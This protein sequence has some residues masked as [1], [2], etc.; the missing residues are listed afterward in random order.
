MGGR[1]WRWR[2]MRQGKRGGG[3]EELGRRYVHLVYQAA[4]RQMGGEGKGGG[5]CD[6]GGF[7]GGNEEDEDRRIAGGGAN[8]GLDF[9]R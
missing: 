9:G 2:M 1:M 6:A 3:W 7:S 8:G 5:G 4:V